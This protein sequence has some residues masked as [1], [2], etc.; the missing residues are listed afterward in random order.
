MEIVDIHLDSVDSTQ[1]YA[2]EHRKEFDSDKI[3]CI[4][5]EEQT[6]GKGRFTRK[7]ISPKGGN[8]YVTFY[9][10]LPAQSLH[11][12]SLG[13]ILVLSVTKLFIKENLCP[14]IKWPNDVLLGGKKVAGILCEMEFE[15]DVAHVFLGI[16]INVNMEEGILHSIDQ[17]ATSLSV[18]T[19]KKWDT[20]TLL[21]DL[22]KQF[23]KDFDI[24]CK[25]GFTPFHCQFENLMA[26]KGEP[27]TCYDGQKEWKGICHSLC[28]DGQ[29]NIYLPNG[30]IKTLSSGDIHFKIK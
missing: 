17:P 3:T 26:Y 1:T 21:K 25:E 6:K 9:F 19:G 28:N 27:V 29:L 14:K 13:Q 11:L 8:L 23:L 22:Q 15:E 4:S 30:D 2:K 24:F 16:G 10:Q 20:K 12:S 18:S 7:W 5:A